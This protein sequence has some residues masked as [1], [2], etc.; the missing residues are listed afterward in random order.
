M[1]GWI[2]AFKAVPWGELIAAAPT[3]VRGTRRLLETVRHKRAAEP[4]PDL[5]SRVRSL[6]AQVAELRGELTSASTLL[7]TMAEQNAR[8]V[9]AVEILRGRTRALLVITALLAAAAIGLLAHAVT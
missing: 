3:V 5:A 6:E 8:L 2:S 1:A 9:D 4:G 7:A